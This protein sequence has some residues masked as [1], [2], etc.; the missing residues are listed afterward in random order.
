VTTLVTGATG[1]LGAN[2]IRALLDKGEKVRVFVRRDSDL[3]A[4]EGLDVE[5]AVGD[6]RDRNSIRAAVK[7]VDK[8]Y[9]TAAFVSIR[10][11]DQQ[12]LFDT[13]VLGTRY[14]MQEARRAGIKR[15]VHTS[16][17]GAVGINP[18]GPSN[19][20]WSVSPFELASDYER[21]KAVSE[22]EVLLEAVRGLDVTIV[23]PAGI[24]GPWDFRPSMIGR[25]ILDFSHGKMPAFVPGAFDFVPVQDV[26]SAELL[27]MEKGHRGERYLVT[28]EY[29]SIDQILD[30]L[31]EFTGSPRPKKS[32]PPQ[33]MQYV[34]LIKD[35]IERKFFPHKAPRFNYHSIRLLNS[36][37]RGDSQRAQRELG[38]LPTSTRQA[39]ADAVMWFKDKGMI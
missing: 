9:H 19:E 27:A 5:H 17:F 16:S 34:A 26:V 8:L 18:N 21:T 31:Q 1:H 24:V 4:V 10:S 12:E 25:T 28:G 35:P 13:N 39:F 36:G 33:L 32:I 29:H 23:N 2:L 20:K 6:L 30:W 15:V 11:G 14:L 22:Q 37:K 38:L 7:G 3:A